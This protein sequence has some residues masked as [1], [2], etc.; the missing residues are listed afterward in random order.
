MVAAGSGSR[1]GRPKQY[2]R[3]G[4]LRVLEHSL[5]TARD[6]TDGVVAVVPPDRAGDDEPLADHVVGGGATRSASVRAGL[7]VVPEGVT[8]VLVHDAARPVR[9]V[10][11]WE[12]VLEALAQGAECVVPVVP[13]TDTLRDRDGGTV[14]RDR[15]VA[16][17]TP[18]GFRADVLRRAHQGEPDGTDDAS[19][20]EAAGAKVTLVDG[21]PRNLKITSPVDLALAE[22]LA[23]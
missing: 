10:A 8:H 21:D 4:G 19:L 15:L 13:V 5:G 14:D 20:A 9:V 18:Q 16:V 6:L 23:R 1:F 17:Q 11:L 7:S 2:E 12:R 3:I 22:L